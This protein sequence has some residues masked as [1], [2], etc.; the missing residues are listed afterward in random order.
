M[1]MYLRI[2]A[3][4]EQH[5]MTNQAMADKTGIPIGT[6]S[7]IRSGK[8][9][10]PGFDNVCA[11][12][13]AMGESID[14]FYGAPDQT[15]QSPC[16]SPPDCPT[17]ITSHVVVDDVRHLAQ[18]AVQGVYESAAIATIN[19]SLAWW[20]FL[21]M[22]L[23]ALVLFFLIWDITH[24]TMG[25]IQYSAAFLPSAQQIFDDLRVCL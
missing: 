22:V 8:I 15:V 12:L 14:V 1:E 11:L 7:G 3:L 10:N 23:L 2:G 24:P 16:T 18:D 9:Q 6:I 21:A 25:Y 17:N 4:M 19:R 5:N 13:A 20:R